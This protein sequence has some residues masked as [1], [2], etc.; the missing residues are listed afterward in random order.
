MERSLAE[1]EKLLSKVETTAVRDYAS[2]VKRI[3]EAF[4]DA[5]P[6][7]E[8]S[9]RCLTVA[10]S[11][12]PHLHE[13]LAARGLE[14][15]EVFEPKKFLRVMESTKVLMR[16]ES[17]PVFQAMCER[18]FVIIDLGREELEEIAKVTTKVHEA[19]EVA[20]QS[21]CP[22]EQLRLGPCLR[23]VTAEMSQAIQQGKDK[24]AVFHSLR[25]KVEMLTRSVGA[26][27]DALGPEQVSCSV[28]FK[29]GRHAKCPE[30]GMAACGDCYGTLLQ[31]K[32]NTGTSAEWEKFAKYGCIQPQCP[33]KLNIRTS[34]KEDAGACFFSC[35][36]RCFL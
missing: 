32:H 28:C 21:L 5:K 15:G 12:L 29:D 10:C 20:D 19:L 34:L 6:L 7:A 27:A 9:E 26:L 4:D 33:G 11:D 17:I 30:C 24:Q 14:S 18:A 31:E 35:A 3:C 1:V 36:G 8:E 2:T 23:G 13:L 22:C 25:R 16:N